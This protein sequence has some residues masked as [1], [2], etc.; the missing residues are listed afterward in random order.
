MGKMKNKERPERLLV[1]GAG[2][3]GIRFAHRYLK[4]D[5]DAKITIVE[6]QSYIGGRMCQSKFGGHTVEMGANWIS[7]KEE[8]FDNPIWK[9]AQT[10][11][12]QGHTIDRNNAS[13]NLIAVTDD[14]NDVTTEYFES[15]KRFQKCHQDA[16]IHWN[17][18]QNEASKKD[19]DVQSVLQQC[20]WDVNKTSQSSSINRNIID[21]TVEYNV[22][23][24]WVCDG[25]DTL[26]A[27]YD[28]REGA[29]DVEMGDDEFFVQ[30]ER[31][32]NY[33]LQ[34][35]V[36][37]LKQNT[38]VSIQ[39]NTEVV[40]I[41]Y[42]K[43]PSVKVRCNN[44]GYE[45]EDVLVADTIICTVSVGVLQS[46][47][48]SFL[49]PLPEWKIKAL[50][51]VSMFVFAKVFVHFEIN[52]WGSSQQIVICSNKRKGYY[53][54]WMQLYPQQH[55]TS[56]SI[57]TS[58]DN[59]HYIFFCYLGGSE[60]Q[61]VES[62]SNE[63]VANEVEELFQGIFGKQQNNFTK[64]TNKEHRSIYRPTA[65]FKTAWSKNKYVRGSY[66]CFPLNAFQ[67]VEYQDLQKGISSSSS[68]SSSSSGPSVKSYD[69][70]NF[71]GEAYDNLYNG[72]VQGGYRSGEY[73]AE[74][75]LHPK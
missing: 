71:A 5:P 63:E 30:D 21:Q 72:W 40:E 2:V 7:G 70:L 53:P 43:N 45:E 54:L 23:E 67:D 59:A 36:E 60:A 3:A 6:A 31:G 57:N 52:F 10:V 32:F 74:K 62:L 20:G 73:L 9:M 11:N 12:L 15:M 44:K 64:S 13:Q 75:L 22:K 50:N 8:V 42:G 25:M 66:S 61:R 51:Q 17:N 55:N 56:S 65:V 16:I 26:S 47:L 33:I 46:D 27:K 48:I 34:P 1:V 49:P 41:K 39:L 14:G 37:D 19:I 69:A 35:M 58:N 24:V 68:S 29:N 28:L 18:Q 4:E 38:N